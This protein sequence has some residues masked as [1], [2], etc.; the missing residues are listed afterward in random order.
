MNGG[1][2]KEAFCD[3]ERRYLRVIQIDVQ[4]AGVQRFET[5]AIKQASLFREDVLV[6]MKAERAAR[7]KV[8]V[9]FDG[10]VDGGSSEHPDSIVASGGVGRGHTSATAGFED[11]TKFPNER[12]GIEVEV[13]HGFQTDDEVEAVVWIGQSRRGVIIDAENL[14]KVAKLGFD[15]AFLKKG[16][17]RVR[18][19]IV[20]LEDADSIAG[21]R[22]EEGRVAEEG[23]DFED[24]GVPNSPKLKVVE[25]AP[26]SLGV[27]FEITVNSVADTRLIGEFVC[28]C[29]VFIKR[30]VRA[31]VSESGANCNSF[32]IARIEAAAGVARLYN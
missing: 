5:G 28:E 22:E 21:V 19:R 24:G 15:L 4:V 20:T 12:N 29:P 11:S 16:A 32:S 27:E 3:A 26:E 8:Q 7:I 10:R 23:P 17:E 1:G 9:V 18:D 14:M 6:P 31:I 2:L 30:H 25:C 13:L